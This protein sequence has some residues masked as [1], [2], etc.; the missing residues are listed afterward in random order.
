MSRVA[1]K[2]A[3]PI[4]TAPAATPPIKNLRRVTGS[5][6]GPTLLVV[7]RLD[8]ETGAT[9]PCHV[10]P[11]PVQEHRQPVAEPNERDEVQSE[12][13]QPRR[14]TGQPHVKRQLGHGGATAD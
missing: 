13:G 14:R 3:A 12:P 11:R 1:S 4:A 7:V 2:P 9:V 6:G 5:T 8:D 10:I